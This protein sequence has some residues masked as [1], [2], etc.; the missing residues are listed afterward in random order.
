VIHGPS[1]FPLSAPAAAL[2]SPIAFSSQDPY[3]IL[4]CHAP[5]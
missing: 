4:N 1:L 5:Y 3:V 2:L